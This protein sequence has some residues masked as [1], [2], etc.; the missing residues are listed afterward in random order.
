MEPVQSAAEAVTP[1]NLYSKINMAPTPE[2]TLPA[3][4]DGV[5]A[6]EST[7]AVLKLNVYLN[8]RCGARLETPQ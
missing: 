2:L 6:L 1:N 3:A 4:N 8:Q 5:I 7:G